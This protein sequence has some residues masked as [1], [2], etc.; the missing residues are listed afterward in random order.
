MADDDEISRVILT[1]MAAEETKS[2]SPLE[3]SLAMKGGGY[4]NAH[5]YPQHV[6]AT[7]FG[8]PLFER[9][10][11]AARI[12]TDEGLVT[13][14]DYACAEGS[15]SIEPMHLAITGIRSRTG[16]ATPV[17]V[18]HTDLPRNDFSTLFSTIL[19]SDGY[20]QG[21]D[22]FSAAVGRSYFEQ[23]LP[24]GSATLGWCANAVH[25]LSGPPCLLPGHLFSPMV[26]D[27]ANHRSWYDVA[28]SDW[29]LF[30]LRRA[31]ELQ[32]G[33]QLVVQSGGVDADGRA[34]GEPLFAV[35]D[36]ALAILVENGTLRAPEA[37]RIV[38]PSYYRND[39]EYAAPFHRAP[40]D[41]LLVLEEFVT[42]VMEDPFLSAYLA[43][44]D[45]TTFALSWTNFLRGFTESVF[46][47][48]TLDRDRSESE[49]ARIVSEFYA[50][51]NRRI[52]VDPESA[53]CRWRVVAMRVRRT[54]VPDKYLGKIKADSHTKRY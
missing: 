9:A 38:L 31:A 28:A 5:A 40:L 3:E 36:A 21:S 47:G 35:A 45:A 37:D 43:D 16:K 18:L 53:S 4:Y 8:L 7:R 54:D 26:P 41:Q 15:N 49:R 1:A 20:G 51:V 12:A 33:G 32:P 44:G 48:P 34:G 29:Q 13:V 52:A 25:W 10:V 2:P 22:V 6:A 42:G 39:D 24:T 11:K 17:M 23:L 46:F 19:H 30:L 14:V 50:E 27:D